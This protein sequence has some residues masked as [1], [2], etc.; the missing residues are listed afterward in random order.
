VTGISSF[1]GLRVHADRASL[2][3]KDYSRL[4]LASEISFRYRRRVYA[5]VAAAKVCDGSEAISTSEPW[6]TS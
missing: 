2:D 4:R 5:G 1:G 3:F 6:A